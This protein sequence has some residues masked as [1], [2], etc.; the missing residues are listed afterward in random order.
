MCVC[1]SFFSNTDVKD[2][3]NLKSLCRRGAGYVDSSGFASLTVWNM[4][5]WKAVVCACVI[6]N[7][8]FAC[9]IVILYLMH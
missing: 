1:V 3:R 5:T 9:R 8:M 4:K 2:L 7:I 6:W